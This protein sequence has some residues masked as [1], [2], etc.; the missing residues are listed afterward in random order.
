[1]ETRN[2]NRRE[3]TT[4]V[5]VKTFDR[6]FDPKLEQEQERLQR[7]NNLQQVSWLREGLR[8]SEG[9]CRVVT[10]HGL[11]TGFLVGPDLVLT[12]AHVIDE[13]PEPDRCWVEFHYEMDWEGKPTPVSRFRLLEIQKT[14]AK[15]GYTLLLVD[16]RPGE[17]FAV[18]PIRDA[19]R[20]RPGSV[21]SRYPVIVQHPR[22]GF[23]H[24]GL[25]G[26]LLVGVQEHRMYYTTPAEPGS[27]GA[28]IFDNLW[29]PMGLHKAGV[30]HVLPN[31]HRVLLNEA[32]IL[33]DIVEHAQDVLGLTD[34]TV[35]V[36]ADLLISGCFDQAVNDVN[37]DWYISNPRLHR[38]IKLDAR[39]A[40]EVIP[41]IAAAAGVAAG[42]ASAHWSAAER[43]P[44]AASREKP[45]SMKLQ[46]ANG[47]TIEIPN[48]LHRSREVFFEEA[49]DRLRD[50]GVF[51]HLR[52]IGRDLPFYETAPHAAAFL[53]GL[54]AGVT[55]YEASAR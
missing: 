19:R 54:R 47:V 32:V 34:H 4:D 37:L 27:S 40:D 7:Y 36:M 3:R 10:P 44:T 11:G 13:A 16:E 26:N 18:I 15:L 35:N 28:P 53:S 30:P 38:A 31:G 21:A 29:R 52:G 45:R 17:R 48:P 50:P 51:S 46:L 20:P 42:A 14:S 5:D 8:L 25:M 1:M 33:A 2:G 22:G 39:G 49:Y 12:A 41:L 43:T 24:L 55:S 9:V 23:K 6:I